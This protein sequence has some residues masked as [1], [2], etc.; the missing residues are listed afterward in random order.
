MRVARL[1][2]PR[3]PLV[4]TALASLALAPLVAVA[5]TTG[6]HLE[7]LRTEHAT[8]PVGID[9]PAPRL[10]WTLHGDRRGMRQTA[11]EIRVATHPD[12]F[13]APVWASGR[14]S[15]QISEFDPASLP[16]RLWVVG[17]IEET[18]CRAT[19]SDVKVSIT[20]GE[21]GFTSDLAIELG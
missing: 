8:N 6:F 7:R 5:Q 12:S 4:A 20:L 11:Y 15:L 16:L 17:M 1:I 9:E 2:P 19:S 10:S 18:A 3:W 21:L 13:A 14:V